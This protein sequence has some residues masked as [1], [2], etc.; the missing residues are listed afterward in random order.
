MRHNPASHVLQSI[1]RRVALL[2]MLFTVFGLSAQITTSSISGLVTEGQGGEPL[3][4]ASVVAVHTPSGTRYATV[5]N[6]DGRYSIE[7]MKPGGPYDIS[8][9]YIGRQTVRL[10]DIVLSL[11][12]NTRLDI[13]LDESATALN[14]V[15]VSGKGGHFIQAKT[16]ATTNISSAMIR[17]MP[18]V[19][20]SISDIAKL[21]PY[22]NGM[23]FAGSDG[24][25]TNFTID[26]SNFNNNFGLTD[27]LPG[28]GNP[29]SLES[30]DEMQIVVSPYDVRQT[31][32]IGGGINAV[33]KSG[34]NDYKASVYAYYTS[35]TFNGSRINGEQVD[36]PD[37]SR[38]IWG[39]TLGGPIIKDKLFYFF[40]YEHETSPNQ[41]VN[42]RVCQPGE[43]PGGMISRTTAADM[44][45]VSDH[46]QSK[47]GY[48]PGSFTSFPGDEK[49]T[50]ILA[51]LDWNITDRHRLSARFNS[52]SNT[53]WIVTNGN[54]TAAYYRLN[55]TYRV[56]TQ[57][58]AFANSMYSMDNDVK[59]FSIDLNS[60]FSNSVSNQLLGTYTFI[61]DMRGSNSSKFPFIDIMN[62]YTPAGD[63]V[64][65]PYM[66]AGYELF[67][68]NNGVKNKIW[69]IKDDVR[70]LLG[71]HVL[72][73]GISFEHQMASNAFMRF[74][75]GYYRYN[76]V[77]DFINGAAPETF[78]L[79]YGFNGKSDPAAE[80]AFNQLGIY[81]QDEWDITRRLKLS[82]GIRLDELFFNDD[83]I[84]RND[85]IYDIDF[86]GRHIDTGRW[87]KSR[88]QVSPRVG[89]NWDVLGDRSLT[90]RGGTGIFTGRLPL[91]FFTNMPTN[92]NMLQNTVTYSTRYDNGQVKSVDPQLAT[93]QGGMITD[94]NEMISHF[95]LPTTVKK[96]VA[97][98]SM[99]GVSDDFKM[100]Q[101]WKTSF[102]VDYKIPV[103]FP[104]YVSG[105]FIYT[106]NFNAVT[107]TNWNIK[108]QSEWSEVQH[109]NGPD[110]RVI[111]PTD[112]SSVYYPK[113]DAIVLTNSSRG[114]GF[115]ES[116]TVNARPVDNLSL[117]ASYT[118]TYNTE[119]SGLPGNQAYSTWQ[120]IYTVDGPNFAVPQTSQYVVPD[121]VIVS[122]DWKIPF[123]YKG[124]ARNTNISLFYNGYSRAGYSYCY[125]ND[126][127]GDGIANDLIYIPNSADELVFKTD[128]DKAAFQAFMDQDK[129]MKNHK[130]QYAEA[131]GARAPW[132]HRFDF[133]L[134]EEFEF[135][136][137]ATKHAIQLSFD[138]MNIGNLLNSH[139]GVQKTNW[140][141]AN[142]R[143]LR[144]EG[145]TADL[146]PIFSMN[147]YNGEY[148]TKSFDSLEVNSQCWQ[149]QVG[150]KYIF[151]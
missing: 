92:S 42:Y 84:T 25:S 134:M 55:G 86:G 23:S 129:Y 57:S 139:W 56:G 141:S 116:F 119:V 13:Y 19:N 82:Y 33:T 118:H 8:Y 16:G 67:T 81:L 113:K 144:Y 90:V 15:V 17:E 95:N 21:S 40:N 76:S 149:M 53:S 47:Y 122:A 110:N 72:T 106:R 1:M 96:H 125:S 145:K 6:I 26:G 48:N 128:A 7:G 4:G 108:P 131:F 41:I 73:G 45:R 97:P 114:H 130:G 123:Q 11:G 135:K 93:L 100:P 61:K 121:K 30:I 44:Q 138:I 31:N 52:T 103:S 36:N 77:D 54:S 126:M 22:S 79:T 12:E 71:S 14:E 51:R 132:T 74:G 105:E 5:T 142:S 27:K 38:T 49:N 60:R 20:R 112:G 43:T 83:D 94:V 146:K 120:G 18:T 85:A 35:Q 117:M 98:N 29:I 104:L 78:A 89:I 62:G 28:G 39:F 101:V 50:R 75:T 66:S 147:K 3:I 133:R 65:E 140:C 127:N 88:M 87:P 63:P 32:F 34:T 10:D 137:G 58:M 70:W 46:L 111:Y 124:C 64:L 143:I 151:N 107:M 68:Y 99:A 80:V 102:G 115:I 148:I 37:F 69:T 2:V 9:S 24:R 150:I 136:I 59:S 109:F 91:V